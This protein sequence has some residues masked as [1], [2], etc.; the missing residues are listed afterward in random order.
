MRHYRGR[1]ISMIFQNPTSSLNPVRRIGR[2]LASVIQL[3]FNVAKEEALEQAEH[4]L[5]EVQIADPS[6]VMRAYPH[7]LSGGMCQRIMIAMALSCRPSLLVADEPTASL[8]VTI[9][10]EIMNLLLSLRDRHGMAILLISHDLGVVSRLCDRVAVM[11]LGRIV[12]VGSAADLYQKPSHPYTRAL[13]ACIPTIGQTRQSYVP[14]LRGELP[15]PLAIPRNACRFQ[16][17]CP[18]SVAICGREDPKLLPTEGQSEVACLLR[19]GSR[20]DTPL[21]LPK[22]TCRRAPSSAARRRSSRGRSR[23]SAPAALPSPRRASAPPCVCRPP[24]DRS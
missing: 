7:E 17:R 5:K 12:E 14:A 3:H 8:D 4:W 23:G 9:Q 6:R 18:E 10:A 19:H 11:Y 24:R 13:L 1:E 22:A 15:S 2:Q 20:G 16:S 21:A